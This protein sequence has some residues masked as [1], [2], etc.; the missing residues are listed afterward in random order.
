MFTSCY[1]FVS[2]RDS[3]AFF[4]LNGTFWVRFSFFNEIVILVFSQNSTFS[5]RNGPVSVAESK[6]S[7]RLEPQPLA[8]VRSEYLDEGVSFDLIVISNI[9]T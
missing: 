8:R 6:V 5:V 7:G 9:Y 3:D 2:F 4:S 1:Y